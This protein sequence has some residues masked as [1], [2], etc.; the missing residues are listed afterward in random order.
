[1]LII[2]CLVVSL[3]GSPSHHRVGFEYWRH[4]GA[5]KEYLVQGATGRFLGVF[6]CVVQACFAYTGTEVVG[7][8]FGEA[9]NPRKHVPEA[10]NQT[11]M[12]IGFFYV[13]GALA[14]GMSVPFNSPK[15]IGATKSKISAGTDD[16]LSPSRRDLLTSEQVRLHSS[17]RV[18]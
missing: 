7:V 12:R 3:G 9:P 13:L 18:N 8:A 6:A 5:F 14:L 15:L 11:L 1:M 16:V 17:L 2:V 10:V 4:P